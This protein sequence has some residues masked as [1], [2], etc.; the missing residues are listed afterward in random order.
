MRPLIHIACRATQQNHDLLKEAGYSVPNT[1][2]PY[3][4]YKL[5]VFTLECCLDYK[6]DSKLF[7]LVYPNV[8]SQILIMPTVDSRQEFC[9]ML[10]REHN[11]K[12]AD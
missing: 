10:M 4:F 11:A 8:L 2:H 3:Q 12:L 1:I 7:L 9:E 5:N 6:I